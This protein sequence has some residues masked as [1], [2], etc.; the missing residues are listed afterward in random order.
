MLTDTH[1]RNAKP[2]PK[3]YRL[4]TFGGDRINDHHLTVAEKKA[5]REAGRG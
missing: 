4:S 3:L 2:K 1:C 5:A